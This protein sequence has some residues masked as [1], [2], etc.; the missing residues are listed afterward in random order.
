MTT[1]SHELE[2]VIAALRYRAY[3]YLLKPVPSDVL[4]EVLAG[5]VL[6]GQTARELTARRM[7]D[8]DAASATGAV[9]VGPAMRAVLG[10]IEQVKDS[11]APV[12]I[13]G[14]S[15]TG[16]EVVWRELLARGRRR[17]EPFVALNCAALPANLVEAELFGF[18]KGAFT[19]AVA[20]K[21]GRFEEAGNGTIFLRR[22]GRAR[23]A[24]PG[25]APPRAPGARGD[26]RRR[27]HGEGRRARRR[28]HAPRPPRRR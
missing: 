7:L 15:G 5:A 13:L 3:D 16:K 21:R 8:P 20:R 11:A 18:E 24:H 26:A 25:E 28:R 2:H 12:T 6:R 10:V 23:A 22:G 14:E 9:F 1:A 4:R 17:S 19:G 27:R